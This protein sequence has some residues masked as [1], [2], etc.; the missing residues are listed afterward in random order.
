MIYSAGA[1]T[2]RSWLLDNSG[3]DHLTKEITT[4][5]HHVQQL[6]RLLDSIE[7]QDDVSVSVQ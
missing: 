5:Q 7:H 3:L 6:A 2:L 1:G 4:T